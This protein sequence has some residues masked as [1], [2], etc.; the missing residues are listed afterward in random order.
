MPTVTKEK[1]W[2]EISLDGPGISI[3]FQFMKDHRTQCMAFA[4][5]PPGFTSSLEFGPYKY[6]V[7]G[8]SIIV[9]DEHGDLVEYIDKDGSLRA[10]MKDAETHANQH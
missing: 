2:C 10:L 7:A 1:G 6:T 3:A 5:S 9:H 8:E 4:Q